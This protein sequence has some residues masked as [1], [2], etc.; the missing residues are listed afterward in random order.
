MVG[1]ALGLLQLLGD[2]ADGA[3]LSELARRSG[4]PVTTTHRLLATLL[5]DDFVTMDPVTKRYTLGLRLFQLGASLSAKRGFG[6][7][8]LPVMRRLSERTGEASLMS[9]LD[10]HNQ[11]YIHHIQ[12]PHGVGVKGETGTPGPLHCTAMGKC[13]VAFA[14]REARARL[15]EELP[16]TPMTPRTI[17]S[18]ARFQSE[19]AAVRRVGYAVV[20]EEH[21]V[22][23]RTIGVPVLS[24]AGTALAALSVPA[25]AYRLA[26]SDLVE[27]LPALREAA[28]ELAVLMP[29]R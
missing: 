16:L 15:L 17:T 20:D 1:K 27:F 14:D 19:I 3:T 8:A 25:P 2:E 22:G 21:E 11:L 24:P 7:V 13:L 9:V 29:Q 12:G 23:I 5:R 28:A 4:Y 18:R 26:V 6:G 10:G